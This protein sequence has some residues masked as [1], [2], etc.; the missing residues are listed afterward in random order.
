MSRGELRLVVAIP[1]T[2]QWE[3]DF[4]M[5]LVFMSN[6]LVAH[7]V[8]GFDGMH[9]RIQNKR[10]SL[11]AN[12]RQGFIEMAV[13]A[14]AT[15]LLFIDSDQTFPRDTAHRL[16]AHKKPVVACNVAT[17]MLPSSPTARLPGGG[18]LYTHEDSTGVR[19][20]WRVGTG[21]MMI[22]LDI[23]RRGPL[24]V[25]DLFPQEWNE[26]LNS[27]V[28]E[29]WG[30]CSRLEAAGVSIFVDQDLSKE[31]GHVGKLEYGHDMVAEKAPEEVA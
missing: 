12:M 24:G 4:G 1:S 9:I 28:G 30:F 16:L 15:H 22:D 3:A 29:D 23:F 6:Y 7:G 27:Y 10:G 31:I 17:K 11:L 2:Q 20:V 25:K 19:P 26:E 18:S 14:E 21:V 13:K 8:D 5:S